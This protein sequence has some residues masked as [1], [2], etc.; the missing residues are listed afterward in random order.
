MQSGPSRKDVR[1]GTPSF[2]DLV[3]AGGSQL[4]DS[5]PGG[6]SPLGMLLSV[7]HSLLSAHEVRIAMQLVESLERSSLSACDVPV[8]T[9]YMARELQ[10]FVHRTQRNGSTG[11]DIVEAAIASAHASNMAHRSPTGSK[12]NLIHVEPKSSEPSTEAPSPRRSGAFQCCKVASGAASCGMVQRGAALCGAYRST[13]AVSQSSGWERDVGA[14]PENKKQQQETRQHLVQQG[15]QLKYSQPQPQQQPHQH[16]A[17]LHPEMSFKSPAA[18]HQAFTCVVATSRGGSKE[19]AGPAGRRVTTNSVGTTGSKESFTSQCMS[20][21]SV[22]GAGTICSENLGINSSV[23]IICDDAAALQTV[24]KFHDLDDLSVEQ[25]RWLAEPSDCCVLP[26]NSL[27]RCFWDL[28]ALAWILM[29]CITIPM[30]VFNVD[31]PQRLHM[32]S[33]AFLTVDIGVNFT[34]GYFRGSI[35]IMRR[36]WIMKHYFCTW[37]AFD[38]I[39]I[40]P[41]HDF[42]TLIYENG[43]GQGRSATLLKIAKMGKLLRVIRLLR[44]A[45]L[46]T[47]LKRLTNGSTTFR[48]RVVSSIC[49]MFVVLGIACHWTACIWGWIGDPSLGDIGHDKTKSRE[50][51]RFCEDA[52]CTPWRQRYQSV[53][54][55]N[56]NAYI[57]ALEFATGIITGGDRIVEPCTLGEHVFCTAM[58]MFS[59]FICSAVVGEILFIMNR[60]SEKRL[61]FDEEI[62]KVQEFMQGRKVPMELQA[63]I[64]RYFEGQFNAQQGNSNANNCAFMNDLS[65]WLRIE[66]VEHLNRTVIEHHPFFKTMSPSMP[67]E[68]MRTICVE[69]ELAFYAPS[70]VIVEKRQLAESAFFIVRGKVRIENVLGRCGYYSIYLQPPNWFGDKCLFVDYHVRTHTAR[71]VIPTETLRIMKQT[72]LRVCQ[73]F[74]FFALHYKTFQDRIRRGDETC[75][76]CSYCSWLGHVEEHCPY[77]QRA[78]DSDRIGP[79]TSKRLKDALGEAGR[80]F[81]RHSC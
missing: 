1:H 65:H 40:M 62:H 28:F 38:V 63:K 5:V 60:E 69:A 16:Q 17:A 33:I 3:P 26:P 48:L 39:S 49:K 22:G 14:T 68:T 35:L 34:T 79:R 64:Q 29:D 57:V 46:P 41:W 36:N 61:I 42:S 67:S 21:D 32:M 15:R 10:S 2:N 37:F 76:R 13:P 78:Y 27:K 55:D 50:G 30:F 45:K 9:S 4:K 24:H 12:Q 72:I 31:T 73:L 51:D 52:D 23:A 71:A 8:T 18:G 58:S 19:N 70:D 56:V 43:G 81:H 20:L 77:S 44:L 80:L 54:N 25:I 75:V 7:V 59:I 74:P 53:Q 6:G 47:I 11:V 66:L